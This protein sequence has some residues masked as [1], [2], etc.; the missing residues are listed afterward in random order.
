M[1]QLTLP[2]IK[3]YAGSDSR[4]KDG[5]MLYQKQQITD[6]S[7]GA[8]NSLHITSSQGDR[9][10]VQTFLSFYPDTGT[11]KKAKCSCHQHQ[12]CEHVIGGLLYAL[13]KKESLTEIL[14]QSKS[15]QMYQAFESILTPELF[16]KEKRQLSL[17]LI[18][19]PRDVFSP[20]QNT[21]IQLK[22][23]G[24]STYVVKH[25]ERFVMAVHEGK[26]Y[27]LT[28]AFVYSP[29]QYSFQRDDMV[30]I[31]LLYDF[32][33]TRAHMMAGMN[34][35]ILT[36][37]KASVQ[38]F[39]ATYVHRL[40]ALLETRS[41][42]LDYDGLYFRHQTVIQHPE[43]DFYLTDEG[44][45][46][47][48]SVNT[49]DVFFPITEDFDYVFYNNQIYNV[50]GREKEAFRLFNHYLTDKSMSVEESMLDDFVNKIKPVLELIGYMHMESS[51]Q[52][53][54][55][56]H[57][58]QAKLYLDKK[59]ATMTLRLDYHYG[60]YKF[61]RYPDLTDDMADGPL[62]LRNLEK[63]QLI[64]G[65]IMAPESH[66]DDQG[67]LVFDSEDDLFYFIDQM[68]PK[69]QQHCEIFYSNDFRST[70]LKSPKQLH[71]HLSYNMGNNL[72]ELDFEMEDVSREE[73]SALLMAVREKRR[74]YKLNDGSFFKIGD[75]LSHQFD[76]LDHRFDLDAASSEGPFL[77]T[78][79]AN[80]FYMDQ[81]FSTAPLRPSYGESFARIIH[82]MKDTRKESAVPESLD[83]ILRDYQKTGFNWL[84]TLKRYGLGG[85]L[86]DDMGLGKT[87]QAIALILEKSGQGPTMVVAPTSLIYNWEEE[88]HRFAPNL[89]TRVIA[90]TKQLRHKAI[91]SIEEND[92]VITSYGSLKR[93]LPI[94][95]RTF[96]HCIID[97]AQHIKNPRSQNATA[98]KTLPA[99]HRFALTGTPIENSLTELWS[100]FD[101]ILP[102]YLGSHSHFVK[103]FEAPIIKENDPESLERLTGLIQP[104][105]LRRLKEDVLSELPPKI[106][107]KVSVALNSH[108]KKLYQAYVQQARKDMD[109]F[110]VLPEGQRNMRVLSV[111]TRLRQLCCHPSLFIDDYGHGSSKLEL[112]LELVHDSIE[113]GHRVLVFSQFTSMLSLVQEAFQ[114]QHI[115]YF[116]LDG[117]VPPIQRQQMVHDFNAGINEVFLI[118]LKAGGTGLNLTGADVVIHYDPWWNPAVEN[119]ATDRA[120]RIG[121][122]NRVQVYRLITTGTIEEKI[123]ELQK[124]KTDLIDSVI[125]PGETFLSK[126]SAA[127]LQSLL[128]D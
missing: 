92:V 102:D 6:V 121:Q 85:I 70:W 112:L 80:A 3:K 84:T 64:E 48:L 19:Q 122:K 31:D 65:Y 128:M 15:S 37:T 53:R 41:F 90:G 106:E 111:L 86:A 95:E 8:K 1:I 55:V 2:W 57:P 68:L 63:E 99:K 120:Y 43:V 126:L 77:Q 20:V 60:P 75:T 13:Y 36:P 66:R 22:V 32:Y 29:E 117:S 47:H 110:N 21:S 7:A 74:Y 51:L 78:G 97:E 50:Q 10:P 114:K 81:L 88:I 101:F 116:Y 27:E 9:E 100:I 83:P 109:A 105:I 82:D 76:A 14:A 46:Y 79:I 39:P 91:S 28:K 18:L 59:S 26:T 113:S 38:S 124:R 12:P 73:L 34:R 30:L 25:I 35:Q 4:F 127:E 87:L 5:F 40:M 103:K 115:D 33:K 16:P 98:V 44:N 94:Y 67:S 54:F 123:Y 69:L 23:N 24:H 45:G 89:S 62:I 71:T 58:L 108:Q 61:S 42:H 17:D 93:D 49:Y 96:E 56:S 107:T 118:S 104:F 11:F 125:R 72:L 52:E 119:Q